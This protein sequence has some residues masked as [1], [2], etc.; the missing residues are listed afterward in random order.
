MSA[1][2]DMLD[3]KNEDALQ[4]KIENLILKA[5]ECSRKNC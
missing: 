4:P 1:C 3:V 5:E 2:K